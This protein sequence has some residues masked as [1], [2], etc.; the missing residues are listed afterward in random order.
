MS[1][2]IIKLVILVKKAIEITYRLLLAVIIL[3]WVGLIIVEYTRYRD[4]KPMLVLLKEDKIFYDDGE[5]IVDY[6]LGYKSITYNR[7]NL[8]GREFGHIFISVREKLPKM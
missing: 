6:G 8:K 1:S 7:S 2:Y 3:L 4:E 5:V